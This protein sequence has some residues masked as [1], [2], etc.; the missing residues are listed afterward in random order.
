M[1]GGAVED[2]EANSV[3]SWLVTEAHQSGKLRRFDKRLTLPQE[4]SNLIVLACARGIVYRSAFSVP[5]KYIRSRANGQLQ[6]AEILALSGLVKESGTE[7][8]I[9]IVQ[10]HMLDPWEG[11]EVDQGLGRILRVGVG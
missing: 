9:N 11:E 2:E 10:I 6:E 7:L 8:I 5:H 3:V 1:G 4:H